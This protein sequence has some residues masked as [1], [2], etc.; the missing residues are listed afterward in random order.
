MKRICAFVAAS[1]L[2]VSTS[3]AAGNVAVIG[4]VSGK[5]LVNKGEGFLPVVGSLE[6][7]AGDRVMVG[8][9]SFATLT[10]SEC[11]VSLAS[12]TVVAVAEKPNCD[13][14]TPTADFAPAAFPLPIILGAVVVGTVVTYIAT[15]RFGTKKKSSRCSAGLSVC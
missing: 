12:P 7:N 3:F 13:V 2:M 8:Q 11:A 6:L 14:I 9:D 10:Y 1:A 15:D 4:D 5:V